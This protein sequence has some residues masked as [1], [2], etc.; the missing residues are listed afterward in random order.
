M[1]IEI[2]MVYCNKIISYFYVSTD[3]FCGGLVYEI[4]LINCLSQMFVVFLSSLSR[5]PYFQD[6]SWDHSQD[7]SWECSQDRSWECSQDR[8][9]DCSQERSQDC[10]WD[11]SQ[12]HS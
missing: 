9:W 1:F 4:N 3:V 10:S 2:L 8:S 7:R 5:F 6:C 11:R 12:E